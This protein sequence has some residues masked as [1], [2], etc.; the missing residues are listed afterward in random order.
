MAVFGLA[1]CVGAPAFGLVTINESF[2]DDPSGRGWGGVGNTTAPNNYG[3]SNTDNTGS[4]VNPPGGTATGAGE[5]GGH[6]NRGPNSFYGLDLGGSGIDPKTT[7][8]SVK[9]VLV[10]MSSGSS[11]TLNF[12]WGQ[13][14]NSANGSGGEPGAL[15]GMSWDDGWNGSGGLRARGNGFGISGAN[16]P[17]L[18]NGGN[19]AAVLPFEMTWDAESGGPGT[20]TLTMNLDGNIGT[21]NI[22]GGDYNDIPVM[23]HWGM[24]GRTNA[25]PD[26]GNTIFIDDISATAVPE[27]ASLGLL[28]LGAL[29]GLR[30]RRS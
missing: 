2:N 12:G 6:V 9:G 30:R 25:S 14:I 17:S 23:T 7:D 16:G 1:M 29:A 26:N 13:G 11:S 15:L 3:F 24:W 4:V 18:T 19:P 10:Q 5:A 22:G 28:S 21:L 27:P 8:M 20:G